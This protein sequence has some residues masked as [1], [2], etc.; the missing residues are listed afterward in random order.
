MG[1]KNTR[2]KSQF[3]YL[4]NNFIPRVNIFADFTIRNAENT[5]YTA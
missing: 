3:M 1:N 4:V 5:R 2:R